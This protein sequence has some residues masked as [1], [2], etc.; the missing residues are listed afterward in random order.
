MR[1]V[2][3]FTHDEP[4][5]RPPELFHGTQTIHTGGHESGVYVHALS[6]EV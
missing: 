4:R 6:L 1:G 5:D 3:W 2:A